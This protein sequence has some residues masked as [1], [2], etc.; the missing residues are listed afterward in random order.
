TPTATHAATALSVVRPGTRAVL[1]EKPLAP[2]WA[3]CTSLADVCAGRG[4]LLAVGHVERFNP[5]AREVFRIVTR[6][7]AAGTL[8]HDLRLS[9]MR[10]GPPPP[11]A[12]VAG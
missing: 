7:C 9:M 12:S 11:C 2:T 10:L 6:L 5:A 3:E 1:V 8:G 4:V